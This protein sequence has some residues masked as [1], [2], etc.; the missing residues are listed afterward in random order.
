MD[1]VLCGLFPQGPVLIVYTA[2]AESDISVPFCVALVYVS[3]CVCLSIATPPPPLPLTPRVINGVDF[4]ACIF[5]TF[6]KDARCL[7]LIDFF[8]I[9]HNKY[10][11]RDKN[12]SFKIL[13]LYARFEILVALL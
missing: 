12:C 3:M 11:S 6:V 8:F 1:E 9:G 7:H 13:L 10:S 4:G 2:L 5:F